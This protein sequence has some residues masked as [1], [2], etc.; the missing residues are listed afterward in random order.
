MSEPRIVRAGIYA[1]MRY[2]V[3][4]KQGKFYISFPNAEDMR[5]FIT[6]GANIKLLND[7]GD[8]DPEEVMEKLFDSIPSKGEEQ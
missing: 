6:N 4:D 1:S 2:V 7:I 3:V 5:L 8:Q